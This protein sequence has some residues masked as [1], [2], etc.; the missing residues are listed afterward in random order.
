MSV[1]K[2]Q[3]VWRFSEYYG[4]Y[5]VTRAACSPVQWQ[6]ELSRMT[7]AESRTHLGISRGISTVLRT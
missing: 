6:W 1:N 4:A 7:C 3:P 2:L 5:S